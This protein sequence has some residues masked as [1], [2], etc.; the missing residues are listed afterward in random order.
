[1]PIFPTRLPLRPAPRPAAPPAGP[2]TSSAGVLG[3]R[4]RAA[5]VNRGAPILMFAEAT[6][7]PGEF[8]TINVDSLR[9]T[10]ASYIEIYEIRFTGRVVPAYPNDVIQISP[11]FMDVDLKVGATKITNN[12]TSAALLGRAEGGPWVHPFG[13]AANCSVSRMKLARPI[14]LAPGEAI[15]PTLYHRCLAKN[16]LYVTVTLVGRAVATQPTRAVRW[17]P[18]IASFQRTVATSSTVTRVLSTEKDLVNATGKPLEVSHIAGR[19]YSM[20]NQLLDDGTTVPS[21]IETSLLSYNIPSL[22]L[23]HKTTVRLTDSRGFNLAVNAP[24]N[25]VFDMARRTW[26][27]DFMLPAKGYIITDT[28]I[29]ATLNA[30]LPYTQFGYALIGYREI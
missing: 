4:A 18:Y 13:Y 26:E 22:G 28:A 5:T 24:F 29:P 23:P 17:L 6:I 11:S 7:N 2:V 25:T 20:L 3:P 27:C 10:T 21:P 19:A 14:T 1:M 9:N 12:P 8:A 15:E 16:S 30:S